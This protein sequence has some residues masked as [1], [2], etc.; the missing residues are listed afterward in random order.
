MALVNFLASSAG[1][2][3]RIV[4]GIVLIVVGLLVVE[5]TGGIVLALIGLVPLA[6][7]LFDFCLVG[8]LLG[9]PFRGAAIR[10]RK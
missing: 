9:A 8:P 10:Q 7:G 6:A 5:G 2:L 3:L 4:A 1:R